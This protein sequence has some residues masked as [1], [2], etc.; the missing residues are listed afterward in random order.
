MGVPVRVQKLIWGT[1]AGRCAMC[2]KR[3]VHDDAG[4]ALSLVGEIAHIVGAKESAAR[5][6]SR[7]T[8]SRASPENLLLLC[9]DHHK[10]IDDHEDLYPADRLRRIRADHLAW[11]DG[12]LAGASRGELLAPGPYR[13]R[14]QERV[15]MRAAA[16]SA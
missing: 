2:R 8:G 7:Y 6:R 12:R 5:G 3:L 1:F 9:R 14:D 10:I 4:G 11:L 15:A 13:V 16:C